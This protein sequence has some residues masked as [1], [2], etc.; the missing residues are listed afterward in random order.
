MSA[1]I[2][3]QEEKRLV[4]AQK[5]LEQAVWVTDLP[6]V[7]PTEKP[8]PLQQLLLAAPRTGHQ[9]ET[10]GAVDSKDED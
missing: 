3:A 2:D 7:S 5:L 8:H 9:A 1:F 6:S 10:A 4:L